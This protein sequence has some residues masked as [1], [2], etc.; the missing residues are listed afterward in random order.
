MIQPFSH[1]GGPGDPGPSPGR[2]PD[3]STPKGRLGHS[4]F[5][6]APDDDTNASF[7]PKSQSFLHVRATVVNGR[8]SGLTWL[9]SR[10]NS[11]TAS[12][13]RS[14]LRFKPDQTRPSIRAS[15]GRE[16]GISLLERLGKSFKIW[17]SLLIS[18]TRPRR[19]GNGSCRDS[20]AC[21]CGVCPRRTFKRLSRRRVDAVSILHGWSPGRDALIRLALYCYRASTPPA[22]SAADQAKFRIAAFPTAMS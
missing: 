16:L 3:R 20:L 6:A 22:E 2:A 12:A 19:E 8:I 14:A 4:R 17:A 7:R 1:P 9:I 21:Q 13:R 10:R 15:K 18:Q 11:T 5:C